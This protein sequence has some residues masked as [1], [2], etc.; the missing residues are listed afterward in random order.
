[1][2]AIP[3]NPFRF[4]TLLLL[5]PAWFSILPVTAWAADAVPLAI[6]AAAPDFDLPGVDDRNYRLRDFSAGN[7]P[8]CRLHL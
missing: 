4:L 7:G 8:G 6:G 1:M 5:L 3:R 2:R